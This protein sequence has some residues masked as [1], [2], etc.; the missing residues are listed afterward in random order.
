[1]VLKLKTPYRD[2]ASHLV[3]SPLEFM[4]QG[5]TMSNTIRWLTTLAAVA[6]AS[7]AVAQS[8]PTKPIRVIVPFAAGGGVDLTTRAITEKMASELKQT[9]IID[10]KGGGGTIIGTEA[11]AKSPGD[12][13]TLF[14]APTTMV[15]SPAL[16]PRLPYDWEKDFVPVALLATLPFVVVTARDFPANN[17]KDLAQLANTKAGQLSFGSGGAGTVAHL[18]GE[19]FAIRAGATMIHAAYKGEAPALTD[20]IGGQISVMFS[21]L[22]SASGHIRSGR[23]KALAVTSRKRTTLLPDVPTVAEQG[24]PDYEVAAWVAL[25]APKGAAT[26]VIEKLNAAA[27][28]AL[29]QK[30][31][32]EKLATLG[33]EP[34]GGTPDELAK[35]MKND[36]Q[37][38]AEVV[39]KAKVKVD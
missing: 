16:R 6:L 24:F 38:W 22:V 29:K 20:A 26:G 37:K 25:V 3:M 8:Y 12:G 4:H 13:Y 33:V 1:V 34:A 30:D 39:K 5:E 10:N 28:E 15:I 18:A 11:A 9:L 27:N 7:T 21:T 2:G 35:F 19:Q 14:A 32:R 23:M 36:A 31:V 17:M